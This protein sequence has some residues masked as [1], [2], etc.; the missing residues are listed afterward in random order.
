M[1]RLSH[2]LRYNTIVQ[3]ELTLLGTAKQ[4]PIILQAKVDV[5]KLS[6]SEELHDHAGSDDRGDTELHQGTSVRRQDRSEPVKWIGRVGRHDTV[7][8]DLGADEE[9]EKG[10]GRPQDLVLE[11]NLMRQ[12]D[13][14]AHDIVETDES[15]SPCALEQ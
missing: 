5:N 15:D 10:C 6:S 4:G 8:R 1:Q 2:Q 7:E 13:P 3:T 14:R 9:D 11:R 12:S